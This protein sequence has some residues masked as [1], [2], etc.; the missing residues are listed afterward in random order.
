MFFYAGFYLHLVWSKLFHISFTQTS[1][2]NI[3]KK[4]LKLFR[5]TLQQ[6]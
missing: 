4:Y 2:A 3:G 1:Q 6:G 5:D